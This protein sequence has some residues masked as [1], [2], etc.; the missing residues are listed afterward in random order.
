MI[1]VACVYIVK[2]KGNMTQWPVKKLTHRT[3]QNTQNIITQKTNLCVFFG[4]LFS[5]GE[6]KDSW[7]DN[8]IRAAVIFYRFVGMFYNICITTINHTVR[9]IMKTCRMISNNLFFIFICCHLN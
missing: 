3:T 9:T 1:Y 7:T 8:E 2:F 6:E 5:F 4:F